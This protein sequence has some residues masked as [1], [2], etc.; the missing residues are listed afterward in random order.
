MSTKRSFAITV[1]ESERIADI[2][3]ILRKHADITMQS[4]SHIYFDTQPANPDDVVQ[5][6]TFFMLESDEEKSADEKLNEL[7]DEL[8]EM[9]TD[10]AIRDE[11]TGK[12]IVYVEFVGALDIMFDNIRSV[13]EGTYEKIDELKSLKTEFGLCKGYKPSF[14][15]MES[16]PIENKNIK[17]ES[18][19]LFCHSQEALMMLKDTLSKRILEIDPDFKLAFRQFTGADPEYRT[20]NPSS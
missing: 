9:D 6:I 4:S 14:R 15:P 18:I 3:N 5:D 13:K 8:D 12:M 20:K 11:D 2:N 10:Y 7:I 19:Y 16:Q 17:P 1:L